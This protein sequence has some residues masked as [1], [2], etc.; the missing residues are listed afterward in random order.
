VTAKLVLEGVKRRFS[1]T[2]AAAVDGVD[3]EVGEGEILVL[4]GPSGC[5]KST[6]LRL[7]AGL[8]EPDAG[9]ILLAGR[10]L[11]RVA[12]QDRDVA[13]VFQGY[14][15]YPHMT[16]RENIGFPLKMRGASREARETKI[17]EVA[18]VLGL[19]KLLD[20]LPGELSGGERQRVAMGRA[21]VRQPKLFLFDEPLSN[22]DAAL[23]TTLRVEIA[24]TLRRLGA[25]AIY[26]THDQVEA[27]T[28]GHRIAVMRSGRVLQEGPARAIYDQP[29]S[30]FVAGFLG[31][32]PVNLWRASTKSGAARLA[33]GIEVAG[34]NGVTLPSEVVLA[35]RPEHV[36]V[37]GADEPAPQHDLSFVAEVTAT[38]PLGSE[39]I[40]HCDG[41]KGHDG[42]VRLR[43][44]VAGF[45]DPAAC[46]R[47]RVVIDR[48]RIGWFDAESESR[49][50]ADA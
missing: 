33:E 50:G 18:Q 15:L 41:P 12:P 45:F 46:D 20:R 8:D 5:G 24:Q 17:D 37:R 48:E 43:A 13:M 34:P 38:E 47:V 49:L 22:L 39:T 36:G 1:G 40:I 32:P 35:V 7:I 19:G 16:V 10:D 29:R 23:R 25:S 3:L 6:I 4:V 21:L 31:T 14:A 27:M 11:A 9:R 30:V 26:V 2:S 28:I 42:P 44:K